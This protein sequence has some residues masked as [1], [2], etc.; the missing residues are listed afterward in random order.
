MWSIAFYSN[1]EYVEATRLYCMQ[2]LLPAS[3]IE[4]VK[5]NVNIVLRAKGFKMTTVM[6]MRGIIILY[7]LASS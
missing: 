6:E 5:Q 3:L 2:I 1:E 7:V 4:V